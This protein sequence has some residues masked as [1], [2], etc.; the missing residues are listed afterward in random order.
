MTTKRQWF[1]CKFRDCDK[2]YT[3]KKQLKRHLTELYIAEEDEIHTQ[4][5]VL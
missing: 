2:I 4:A 1:K 3:R 5:D